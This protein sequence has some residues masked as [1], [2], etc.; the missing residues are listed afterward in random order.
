M[1]V[2]GLSST[3]EPMEGGE[4]DGEHTL[5]W[6]SLGALEFKLDAKV[7]ATCKVWC[8]GGLFDEEESDI[9][10]LPVNVWLPVKLL[11]VGRAIVLTTVDPTWMGVEVDVV[12]DEAAEVNGL[13]AIIFLPPEP[14][15]NTNCLPVAWSDA[16]NAGGTWGNKIFFN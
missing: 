5:E 11:P 13:M 10:L 3:E 4:H 1:G 2:T 15:M 7:V 9:L 14:V 6:W 8:G 16:A 12:V